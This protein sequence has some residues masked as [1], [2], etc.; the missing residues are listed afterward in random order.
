MTEC[1]VIFPEGLGVLPWMVPGGSDIALA[2]SKLMNDYS[3]V[4]WS[5][6][7]IFCAGSSLDEAFGLMHTIE[8][9]AEIYLKQCQLMSCE[10]YKNIPCDLANQEFPNTITDENLLQIGKDFGVKVR[11]EFLYN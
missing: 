10:V 11:K 4:V 7:G 5:Q 3:S 8:K 6:H 9:A 2:T 1:I